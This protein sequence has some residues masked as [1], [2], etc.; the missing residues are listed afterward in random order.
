MIG[1][2]R[3]NASGGALAQSPVVAK[4]ERF[5]SARCPDKQKQNKMADAYLSVNTAGQTGA[6]A[7]GCHHCHPCRRRGRLPFLRRKSRW[8]A[9]ER[10]GHE[11][12]LK[13]RNV[14]RR[15]IVWYTHCQTCTHTQV[16]VWTHEHRRYHLS[17]RKQRWRWCRF[18]LASQLWH[19]AVLL[20][21]PNFVQLS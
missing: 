21:N 15:L 8:R 9:D 1:S 14:R 13:H 19:E 11:T 7:H 10:W 12:G 6:T 17:W 2:H 4:V 5:P 18:M 16:H 20:I 3:R